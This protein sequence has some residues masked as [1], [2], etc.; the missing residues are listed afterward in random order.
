VTF[1]WIAYVIQQFGELPWVLA[2]MALLLFA[3]IGQPQFYI[4]ALPLRMA[5]QRLDAVGSARFSSFRALIWGFG[6]ALFYA[7][8]D[9]TL[10]KL[11][12]D[13]LGHPLVYAKRLKQSADTGGPA[14]LT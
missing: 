11:F 13:T 12:V 10:P 3:C 14:F 6:I 2:G 7:G 8:L 1:S 5:L 9:W 4:A